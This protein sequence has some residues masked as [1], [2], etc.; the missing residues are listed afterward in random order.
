MREGN[1][2]MGKNRKATS[3]RKRDIRPYSLGVW[4]LLSV[5]APMKAPLTDVSAIQ[6]IFLN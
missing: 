2:R 1:C 6:F 5:Q 4:D 3:L